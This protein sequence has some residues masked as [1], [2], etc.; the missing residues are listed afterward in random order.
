MGHWGWVHF[1]HFIYA[2]VGLLPSGG[3]RKLFWEGHT[4]LESLKVTKRDAKG[5][6]VRG[7][8]RGLPSATTTRG[9]GERRKLQPLMVFGHYKQ[10]CAISCMSAFWNLTGKANKTDP[11]WPLVPAIGLEEARAPCAPP[12]GSA[13][14]TTT[15]NHYIEI[16][17]RKFAPKVYQCMRQ[18]VGSQWGWSFTL[19]PPNL[20]R[21][22]QI[23]WMMLNPHS[24]STS[25]R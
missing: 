3:S 4:G 2:T 10:F 17:A 11:I 15:S 18:L 13:H 19:W 22:S 24:T 1:G 20:K 5:V 23:A 21:L 16:T 7:L 25:S 12:Y 6:E 8:G 9:L 14:T